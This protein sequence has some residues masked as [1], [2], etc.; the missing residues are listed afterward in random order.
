LQRAFYIGGLQTVRGQ[1]PQSDGAGHAGDSFWLTRAEAGP[2][3]PAFRPTVFYDIGWAGPRA[4]FV[5]STHPLSGAGV[6][7][8]LLDGLVKLDAAR[9]L[10]RGRSWRFD[11][12]LG[13][14][15]SRRVRQRS[16]AARGREI[17]RSCK[18]VI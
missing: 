15:F 7:L 11:M 2:K 12:S 13:A 16:R 18:S 3:W 1:A 17:F 4:D 6:G 8:A 14:R 5:H 9:G 10:E